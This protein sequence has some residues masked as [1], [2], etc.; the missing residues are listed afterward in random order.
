M[1]TLLSGR[2]GSGGGGGGPPSGA[3]GGDLAGTYP[4]PDV[5]IVDDDVLGSGTPSADT[6]LLGD[7]SWDLP[8]GYE[9]AYAQITAPVS[10]TGT[11]HAAPTDVISSGAVTY[12]GA[13]I[14]VEF[15]APYMV[16]GG[17]G[18]AAVYLDLWDDVTAVARIAQFQTPGDIAP[19]SVLCVYL[20][21]SA[22]S[23]TYR[24]RAYR[25]VANGTI[26][27]G[28]SGADTPAPAY[29]RVSKA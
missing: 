27:A 21:P 4:N 25:D 13:R 1:A 19:I 15:F 22:A 7:R 6:V 26:G 12:D 10:V 11:S 17:G 28:A 29:I 9:Y 8:S 16:V 14:A 23:H 3:A 18:G 2:G 20:T 5:A 24:I